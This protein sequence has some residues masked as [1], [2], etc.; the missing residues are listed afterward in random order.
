MGLLVIPLSLSSVDSN[1]LLPLTA[2][3]NLQLSLRTV[4]I[5]VVWEEDNKTLLSGIYLN[6][7]LLCCWLLCGRWLQRCAALLGGRSL[8]C[9]CEL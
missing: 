4:Y 5:N 8:R 6:L 7:L 1:D 2:N 9:P 3:L